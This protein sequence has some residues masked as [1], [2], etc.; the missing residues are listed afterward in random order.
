MCAAVAGPL[1]PEYLTVQL[2]FFLV[3]SKVNVA[4]PL[5]LVVTGGFCWLPSSV[6]LYFTTSA[7]AGEANIKA[8]EMA[9]A[10]N[11]GRKECVRMKN[12]RLAVAWV[13]VPRRA[14]APTQRLGGAMFPCTR[15]CDWENI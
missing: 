11:T 6:A 15:F 1:R 5:P 2:S 12:L 8:V 14:H 13:T 3:V 10:E 7:M 4:V 9:S